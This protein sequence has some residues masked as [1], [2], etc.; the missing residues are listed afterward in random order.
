MLSRL[1]RRMGVIAL[2]AAAFAAVPLPLLPDSLVPAKQ[3]LAIFAGIA[4]IGKTLYDTLF[5][6]RGPWGVRP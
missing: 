3:A 1:L 6:P 4:C 2:G 5:L